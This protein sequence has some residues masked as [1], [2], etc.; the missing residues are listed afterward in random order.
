MCCLAPLRLD[1][2]HLTLAPWQPSRGEALMDGCCAKGSRVAASWYNLLQDSDKVDLIDGPVP[3]AVK[4]E[5][6]KIPLSA[7]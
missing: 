6:S 5:L 2:R 4:E 7:Q 3:A 1:A